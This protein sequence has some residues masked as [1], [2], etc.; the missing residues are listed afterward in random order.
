MKATAKQSA[1][2]SFV[3]ASADC[4]LE[5]LPSTFL[6]RYS[7]PSTPS[8]S[9]G[10]CMQETAEGNAVKDFYPEESVLL[11]CSPAFRRNRDAKKPPKGGTTNA[12][13]LNGVGQTEWIYSI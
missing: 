4:S 6:V 8:V 3:V 1:A 9:T 13:M 11:V 10:V 5:L 2:R 7:E 12:K